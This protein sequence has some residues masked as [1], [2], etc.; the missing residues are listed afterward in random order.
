[1]GYDQNITSEYC[2]LQDSTF[3]FQKSFIYSSDRR[4]CIDITD[5]NA[6][7]PNCGLIGINK[8]ACLSKTLGSCKYI[9]SEC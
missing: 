7:V 8:Y 3:N 5:R 9:N 6:N 4:I 1:M 2:K